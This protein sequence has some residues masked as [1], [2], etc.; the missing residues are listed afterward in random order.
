[1]RL[2]KCHIMMKINELRY[3]PDELSP[4]I[5]V[6]SRERAVTYLYPCFDDG[7]IISMVVYQRGQVRHFACNLSV[8]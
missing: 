1:M 2:R 3:L 6:R 5:C 7:D 4:I 8:L